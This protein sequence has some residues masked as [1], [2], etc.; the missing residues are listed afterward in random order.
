[1]QGGGRRKKSRTTPTITSRS[2]TASSLSSSIPTYTLIS[3]LVKERRFACAVRV[4]REMAMMESFVETIKSKVKALKKK[5]SSSSS[6]SKKKPYVKMDKSASVKV[7]IRSRK[8]RKLIDKTLKAADRP[9]LQN[10][11]HAIR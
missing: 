3:P 2:Q 11:N 7:E 10:L 4:V 8:A 1:M 9:E 6:S 5:S